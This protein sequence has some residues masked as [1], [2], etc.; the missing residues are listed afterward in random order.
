MWNNCLVV[1][2]NEEIENRRGDYEGIGMM[3]VKSLQ[4]LK[5][6]E[7]IYMWWVVGVGTVA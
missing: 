2:W 7:D 6:D 4:N 1:V 5:V 3:V